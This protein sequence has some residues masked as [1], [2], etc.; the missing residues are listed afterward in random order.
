MTHPAATGQ[1][2]EE[3]EVGTRE[4]LAAAGA[5][6]PRMQ[7]PTLLLVFLLCSLMLP[8]L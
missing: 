2:T 7:W 5:G 1:K 8:H 6:T 3:H 4:E